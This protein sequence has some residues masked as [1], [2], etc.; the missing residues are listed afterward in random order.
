[1]VGDIIAR[2]YTLVISTNSMQQTGV[3]GLDE[4]INTDAFFPVTFVNQRGNKV[5]TSFYSADPT[6]KQ[7]LFT[8]NDVFYEGAKIE[9]IE[10]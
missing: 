5:T 6:Y 9:L 3:K 7:E 4:A 1:M 2:K 10:Q 8:K